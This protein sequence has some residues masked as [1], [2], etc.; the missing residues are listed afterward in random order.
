MVMRLRNEEQQFRQSIY[1]LICYVS[2]GLQ[3]YRKVIRVAMVG[4]QQKKLDVRNRLNLLHYIL[5]AELALGKSAAEVRAHLDAIQQQLVSE[6]AMPTQV[7]Y[8]R[9][10]EEAT[11]EGDY[12]TVFYHWVVKAQVGMGKVE[13][14]AKYAELIRLKQ[15]TS[16]KT[17]M[18][19][20]VQFLNIQIG[21]DK[22][23]VY[24]YLKT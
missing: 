17:L 21:L 24:P 13:E 18:R 16:L 11:E 15:P 8:V 2:L 4:L 14:A 5:E 6:G 12:E 22:K 20:L 10:K 7:R 3:L 1:T 23:F 19:D 9:E